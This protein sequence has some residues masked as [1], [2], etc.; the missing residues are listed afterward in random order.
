MTDQLIVSWPDHISP[1]WFMYDLYGF[2]GHQNDSEAPLTLT[3][4]T[5][6]RINDV[7]TKFYV[8]VVFLILANS[9]KKLFLFVRIVSR[10]LS[11]W[12]LR[13]RT[14][15]RLRSTNFDVISGHMAIS[16]LYKTS[17]YAEQGY[18]SIGNDARNSIYL[19]KSTV[20]DVIIT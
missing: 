8:I 14:Y 9:S 19:S 18:Q 2:Y 17:K 16:D 12:L 6:S 4:V 15:F 7:I 13:S 3:S 5:M 1:R 20:N 10:F 11:I